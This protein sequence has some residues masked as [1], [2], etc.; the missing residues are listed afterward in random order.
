METLRSI[1]NV[2][3]KPRVLIEASAGT[4]K[5]YTIVGL[6]VRLLAEKNLSVDQI[7]VMT[8]TKKATAEL[9]DRIFARLQ[10]CLSIL[11]GRY[12]QT[13][14]SFLQEFAGHF[15]GK[16]GVVHTIRESIRNF[17]ENQVT[18][19]H[20]FCQKVLSEEALSAGTPLRLRLPARM[21]C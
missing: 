6:F 21:N 14:D 11:E 15:S 13:P 12:Q 5:T 9:R 7:L 16:P 17:D 1:F 4:G 20:G 18:T 3:W 8:F 10:D 19:I 2:G